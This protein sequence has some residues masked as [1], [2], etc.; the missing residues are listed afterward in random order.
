MTAGEKTSVLVPLTL[1][2]SPTAFSLVPLAPSQTGGARVRKT[3]SMGLTS[4][5]FPNGKGNPFIGRRV[6]VNEWW[7]AAPESGAALPGRKHQE[8]LSQQPMPHCL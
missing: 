4:Y 5:V 7:A 2:P 1:L 6:D 8:I 3:G